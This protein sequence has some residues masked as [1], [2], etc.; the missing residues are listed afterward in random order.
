MVG[1]TQSI[2]EYTMKKHAAVMRL[3]NIGKQLIRLQVKPPQGDFYLH[4]QQVDLRPGGNVL[5]PKDHLR[6][7]QIRNLQGRRMLRI[8]YDSENHEEPG[9][10]QL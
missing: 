4:E 6:M 8:E 7:D 3:A 10:M 5:L 1:S 2:E 9:M